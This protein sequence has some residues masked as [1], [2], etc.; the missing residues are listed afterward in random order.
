MEKEGVGKSGCRKGREGEESGDI[1]RGT[2]REEEPIPFL[3][4]FLPSYIDLP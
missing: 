2:E 1:R 3:R 4:V